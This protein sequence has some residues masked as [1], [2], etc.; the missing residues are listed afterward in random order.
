MDYTL[1]KSHGL[2]D[3][4]RLPPVSLQSIVDINVNECFVYVLRVG[5]SKD[6]RCLVPY[7]DV[8]WN[9]EP[10][11]NL[12]HIAE[13]DLTPEDVE[14]VLFTQSVMI[15]AAHQAG[16]WCM[17]SRQ[18]VATPLWSTRNLTERPSIQ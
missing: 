15:Q 14:E 7:Y 18:M 12:A 10:N 2:A 1:L 16:Q 17:A 11:G 5:Q 8:L 4:A 3:T 13:H 6:R 9:P